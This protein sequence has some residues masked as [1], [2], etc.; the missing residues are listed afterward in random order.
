MAYFRK[1]DNGWEYRISYKTPDGKYKQK[2]KSGF[3]TKA[4][5][6]AAANEAERKLNQNISLD[7][8]ITFVEYFQHWMATFKEASLAK[9]TLRNYNQTLNILR[10]HF[11][12]TKLT[13]ITNS[14]YQQFLNQLGQTYYYGTI[15]VLHHRLR[16][17]VKYAIADRIISHNFTDLAIITAEKKGKPIEEKFLQLDEY[18]QLLNLSLIHI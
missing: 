17:C 2:S 16:S 12:D 8:N 15:R 13:A 18:H 3:K 14:S 5:A 1:R 10:K 6:T 4:L 11:K 9:G 7:T